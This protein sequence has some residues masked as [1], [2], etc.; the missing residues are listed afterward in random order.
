M[1]AELLRRLTILQAQIVSLQ[2]VSI[3][4]AAEPPV[5]E[6][7]KKCVREVAAAMLDVAALVVP[8]GVTGL[9][10]KTKPAT[11]ADERKA[12]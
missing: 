1:D 7:V 6:S 9:A 11:D 3:N 10:G 2:V 12:P 8:P 4:P 5:P